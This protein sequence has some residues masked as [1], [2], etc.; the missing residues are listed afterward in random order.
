MLIL[1]NSYAAL[2]RLSM[3]GTRDDSLFIAFSH[4]TI[5]RRNALT[6]DSW[7]T[8]TILF[9]VVRF[10]PNFGPICHLSY[11]P[12]GGLANLCIVYPAIDRI[13]IDEFG[14]RHPRRPVNVILCKALLIGRESE[15][16]FFVLEIPYTMQTCGC[17]L[18]LFNSQFLV[19]CNIATVDG[20]RET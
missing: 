4:R 9:S 17:S 2:R 13:F 7:G 6:P 20:V 16:M 19:I 10:S 11:M 18:P 12:F 3:V 1:S 5:E 14:T 15:R 8:E